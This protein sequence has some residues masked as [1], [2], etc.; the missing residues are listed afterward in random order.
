MKFS[1]L[2][3]VTLLFAV[4]VSSCEFHTY[5]ELQVMDLKKDLY[6]THLRINDIVDNK[7]VALK[8]ISR[9]KWYIYSSTVVSSEPNFSG[10]IVYLSPGD[11]IHALGKVWWIDSLKKNA[12]VSFGLPMQEEDIYIFQ[13]RVAKDLICR[14]VADPKIES[15][16]LKNKMPNVELIEKLMKQNWYIADN[17]SVSSLPDGHGELITLEKDI[18]VLAEKYG[19]YSNP[20]KVNTVVVFTSLTKQEKQ[21]LNQFSDY[22]FGNKTVV[23]RYVSE[24][25]EG[26]FGGF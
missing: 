4:L 25:P 10:Q 6:D 15:T 5:E 21:D 24:L 1:I 11:T 7:N 16:V 18:N 17:N 12:V 13:H 22:L 3:L 14:Y 23:C 8:L 2:T 19:F 26:K 9:D 20:V